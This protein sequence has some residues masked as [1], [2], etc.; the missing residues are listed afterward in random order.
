MGHVTHSCVVV[1]SWKDGAIPCALAVA[2]E[3]GLDALG[4]VMSR[5]NA[6]ETMMVLPSGSK[7]G[8]PE[9]IDH[10]QRLAKFIDWLRSQTYSDGSSWLEWFQANYGKDDSAASV[11]RTAW[12]R[13]K[14]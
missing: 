3:L 9:A 14:R 7:R 11:A 8:W 1:T 10:D 4:P 13:R 6:F 5:F 2:R 12:E